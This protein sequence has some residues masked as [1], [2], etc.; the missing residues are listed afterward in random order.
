MD[1]AQRMLLTCPRQTIKPLQPALDSCAPCTFGFLE[2]AQP[3]WPLLQGSS[4]TAAGLLSP[5]WM[6]YSREDP[7][8]PGFGVHLE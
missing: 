1:A 6:I 8:Q 2:A 4:A 7:K 3:I 5:Q